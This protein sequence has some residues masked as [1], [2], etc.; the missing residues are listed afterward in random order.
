MSEGDELFL[1]DK[2]E[3]LIAER[4]GLVFANSDGS[5]RRHGVDEIVVMEKG[6]RAS[7]RLRDKTPSKPTSS[8]TNGTTITSEGGRVLPMR[9]ARNRPILTDEYV[10]NNHTTL[11]YT[12]STTGTGKR[13]SKKQ[14]TAASSA[15]ATTTSNHNNEG[16]PRPPRVIVIGAGISGL[17][18]ARELSERQHDVL[19]LEARNRLGGRLRTIDLML[20]DGSGNSN[21]GGGG[22]TSSDLYNVQKW[23][24]VD[25]GGAFIHGTGQSTTRTDDVDDSHNVGSHDFRTS[26]TGKS[27]DDGEQRRRQ[28]Q[29]EDSK[30]KRK[31]ERLLL[32]TSQKI[33]PINSSNSNT[34]KA[35]SNRNLN[36]VFVLAQ[37]KLR[38][39]V[40][41]AEG[42]FTCLVDHEGN[43]ISEVVD[44]EVAEEF[45]EVLDMAT[46][47]CESGV[48]PITAGSSS[49]T[50]VADGNGVHDN[51]E[52]K[53]SENIAIDSTTDF[54]TIFEECRKY[55]NKV[56]PPKECPP[57][58]EKVRHN[59]FQWH[60]A[61]LEMSS[62]PPVHQLGPQWNDDEPYGYGG[63]HSCLK[64]GFR[65]V[66]EALAEGFVCKGVGDRSFLGG[67]FRRS[68]DIAGSFSGVTPGTSS[69]STSRGLIQCGIEVNGVKIVERGRAK[70][71]RKQRKRPVLVDES[72]LRRS[73]R[74]SKGSKMSGFIGTLAP[75]QTEATLDTDA[76]DTL[77]PLPSYGH[78]ESTVVHV[79]TKCGVTL[80]ADAVIVTM[81][82]AILS[83][84]H[85][86]PGH[87]AFS[88]PLPTAKQN[89]LHRIGVGS[90]A[91]CC[92]SFAKPFWKHLPRHLSSSSSALPSYWNDPT[93]HRFDFIGHASAE[94][95]KNILF[96]NIR[97]APILVAIYGG[98]DYSKEIEKRHD[99]DVVEG[100]MDVLKKL[101]SKA[102]DDCRLTRSQINDLTVPDWP[103]DYFVSRW[104][105]DPFSRGAFSYV[106]PGVNGIDE[107][108]A[109]SEP[110]HDFRPT[111]DTSDAP[112]RP[113]VQ[114]AG[115]A[116]TPFHPSTIHGAFETG[117]REG[118]FCSRGVLVLKSSPC[119]L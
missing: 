6:R 93:T 103:V 72:S 81:P 76:D 30:P 24:P 95:G 9:A 94:H 100:C 40:Q 83:I 1:R 48:L 77:E 65:D 91:K 56:N 90:Y 25:V 8:A 70:M 112:L 29:T 82:L 57:E 26:R 92:M 35:S 74:Q 50:Y 47:C 27:K 13:K 11:Q 88:P 89:A 107:F 102:T 51:D 68:G 80:E 19:V 116:T 33:N 64:G 22:N 55:H 66:I 38:L 118:V 99:E 111:H 43:M 110:I 62:G 115:E 10:T 54:G 34:K 71:L 4:S 59:L 3:E 44:R 85:G 31:S 21:Q 75:R 104:G 58:E 63:D 113:L 53:M 46:K 108:T 37:Q 67:Q 39:P 2:G 36:P 101:F 114:F 79:T 119:S 23:S 14:S 16:T 52:K 73:N 42:A 61:N 12:S 96:F 18:A 45:N 32:D 105:S 20:D 41:A 5:A 7:K 60:V 84:P 17:A 106:P 28:Q 98:S 15:A 49:P 87:I 78:E 117:I 69:S 97:D 109:M 86:S